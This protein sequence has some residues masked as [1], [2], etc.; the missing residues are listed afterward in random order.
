[1]KVAVLCGGRGTRMGKDLK[2]LP[3]AL[4][5]IGKKPIIWHIMKFYAQFGFN[6]FLLCL[7]YKGQDI[8]RYF[9][10]CREFRITFVDTGL[11]TNTGGRI[12]RIEPYIDTDVFMATYGDGLSNVNLKALLRAHAAHGK[13]ATL[14]AVRPRSTFGIVGIDSHTGMISHFDE[15]PLLDH[16]IN[17]G[18]FVFQK[19]VFGHVRRGDILEKDTFGRL[20]GMKEI[21]AYKHAGFWECMDT[22]KDNI[23]LNELW[24]SKRPP[25][26]L[27][28]HAGGKIK[29]ERY[30]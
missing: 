8:E 23:H 5:P 14:T 30:G 17:G 7:G 29:K 13:M 21:G 28:K 26:A 2:G 18:F 22:Y 12:K 4:M 3:K 16:W 1:M 19:K 15:K 10:H 11:E 25:W 9:R 20:V 24:A 6:D 27:W